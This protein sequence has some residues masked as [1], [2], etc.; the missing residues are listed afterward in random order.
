MEKRTMQIA[1]IIR[2]CPN[3]PTFLDIKYII[4]PVNIEH[5]PGLIACPKAPNTITAVPDI[6]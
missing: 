4:V 6:M 2:N 1:C 5:T 3:L